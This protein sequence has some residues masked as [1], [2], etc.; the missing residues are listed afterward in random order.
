MTMKKK[1]GLVFFAGILVLGLILTVA[2]QTGSKTATSDPPDGELTWHKYDKALEI[3]NEENKHVIAYFTTA[4]CGYCKIMQK[5]TFKDPDVMAL[6]VN[7]FVLA[8]TDGDSRNVL[9]VADKS[10]KV[11]DITERQLT[12]AFGVR[13]FPTFI[14]LKPDGTGIAPISGYWKAPQFKIALAYISTGSY[15]KMQFSE[16]SANYKG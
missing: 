14:F 16:F 15:E 9:K 11:V 6:M 10:G 7:D 4:W 13:G 3:A 2:G 5:T 1:I 8:W 12:K